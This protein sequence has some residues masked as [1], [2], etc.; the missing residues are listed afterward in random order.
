[1]TGAQISA[2]ARSWIG[3][4]YLHQASVKGAGADCLG[5]VRGVWRACRGAE[6]S[7]V[8]AYTA[9][10]AEPSRDE[11]L[12]RSA[13]QW[14]SEHDSADERVGDVLLFRMARG[15]VAKHLGIQVEVGAN[16]RFVHA[17]SRHGV[18]ES[19][20]SLPWRQRLVTRFSFP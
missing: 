10:W 9:D 13:A 17:Y 8:P 14:L 2:E 5:L 11:A 15:A 7:P 3:T 16:A 18:V 12:W 4:P 20:L 1:M 6:P 19:A